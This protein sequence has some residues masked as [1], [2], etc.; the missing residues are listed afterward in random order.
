MEVLNAKKMCYSNYCLCN[1]FGF[2]YNA[3]FIGH[4]A[5]KAYPDHDPMARS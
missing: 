5:Q 4:V 1:G 2:D 3:G